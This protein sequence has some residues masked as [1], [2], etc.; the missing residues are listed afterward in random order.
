MKENKFEAGALMRI[1][2]VAVCVGLVVLGVMWWLSYEE[3]VQFDVIIPWAAFC[4]VVGGVSSWGYT[5]LTRAYSD[6]A[7]LSD[8]RKD[9]LADLAAEIIEKTHQLHRAIKFIANDFSSSSEIEQARKKY[10]IQ[11][12]NKHDKVG[13]VFNYR[14]D[15][16]EE[17]FTQYWRLDIK[18]RIYFGGEVEKA[19]QEFKS[20]VNSV[21]ADIYLINDLYDHDE[22]VNHTYEIKKSIWVLSAE[23]ISP[24]RRVN[25]EAEK[26]FEK[27]KD[28]PDRIEKALLKYV[29][30]D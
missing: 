5:N 25:E 19:M 10:G 9:K 15:Q 14:Y 26:R 22:D 6:S 30:E 4:S 11:E 13:I 29:R 1:V 18:A 20:I 24:G 21:L 7:R 2:V 27:F 16:V 3:I 28:I 17:V 12:E 23:Y 8:A